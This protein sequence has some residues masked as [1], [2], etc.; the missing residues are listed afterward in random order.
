MIFDIFKAP[1]LSSIS[2]NELTTNVKNV[3]K[4]YMTS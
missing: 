2:L 3:E 4:S 1:I